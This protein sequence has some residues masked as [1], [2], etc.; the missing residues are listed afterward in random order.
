M[1]PGTSPLIFLSTYTSFSGFLLLRYLIISQT[2]FLLLLFIHLLVFP[3]SP[4]HFSQIHCWNGLPPVL[5]VPKTLPCGALKGP[6]HL[7]VTSL[8]FDMFSFGSIFTINTRKPMNSPPLPFVLLSWYTPGTIP[9]S[10]DLLF[11]PINRVPTPEAICSTKCPLILA[12]NTHKDIQ[13]DHYGIVIGR[14]SE[15]FFELD[16]KAIVPHPIKYP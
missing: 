10:P 12:P 11:C 9:S 7:L 4:L 2:R 3:L 1:L 16:P 8:S 15:F 5:R 6:L 14:P 13:M